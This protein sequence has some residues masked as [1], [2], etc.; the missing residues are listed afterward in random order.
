MQELVAARNAGSPG[1]AR[2]LLRADATYWDCRRGRLHGRERVVAALTEPIPGEGG[3][4][5]ELDTLAAGAGHAVAE[6]RVSGSAPA[7]SFAFVTT[8]V[9]TVEHDGIA[10]CRAYFDPADLPQTA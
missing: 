9:Y 4:R 6:L 3:A 2:R 7:G 10:A 5:F 1:D 8:E